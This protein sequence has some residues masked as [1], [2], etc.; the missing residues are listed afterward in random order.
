MNLQIRREKLC[1]KQY[2][3]KIKTPNH[4]LNKLPTPC[5]GEHD[6]NLRNDN[7]KVDKFYSR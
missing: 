6:F 4:L 5:D 1:T 2:F 7:I 3:D